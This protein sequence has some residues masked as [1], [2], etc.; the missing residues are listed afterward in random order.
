MDKRKYLERPAHSEQTIIY[1]L[2]VKRNLAAISLTHRLMGW[3]LY[4]SNCPSQQLS[5][6]QAVKAYRGAP[7][8][9]HNF[10]R[11]KG[12]PLGIRPL[13]VHRED[14]TKGMVRLLSL[15]L[16]VLT[17]TEF[18]VRQALSLTNTTLSGLYSGNPKRQTSQP[19]TE[20]LLKAF[21]GI[22][23]SLVCLPDQVISHITPLSAL[24]KQILN[25]LGFSAAIYE[26]IV[27]EFSSFSP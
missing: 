21:K 18:V 13:Y 5:F 9:E 17:V 6:E 16:R 19:T 8:M 25:L 2:K 15:A 20:R 12:K 3:R 7:R 22:T 26:D 14:H 23:L 11:L 27:V 10:S 24:Q 1:K 4:V